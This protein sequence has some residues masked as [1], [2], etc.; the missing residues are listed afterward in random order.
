MNINWYPLRS[1]DLATYNKYYSMV[2]TNI[3]DLTFHCRFAW[4][5]VFKIQWTILEDCLVQ[6]SSG[7]G[8]SAPFM[9]MPLGKLTSE[10]I[11]KIIRAVHPIFDA[12]GWKFRILS[13]EEAVINTFEQTG[14]PAG[15]D[16]K[17]ESSDYFYDAE[18]L[19]TLAGK[20]YSKKRNHWSKFQRLYP[21]YQYESLSPAI[22]DECLK[23]VRIWAE[24]KGIDIADT[25]DSDYY[26]IKRVFDHWQD[27]EARGGAIRIDGK[28]VA[29]SIG[30]VGRD[31]VGFI[32]FEK[33]DIQY[34]GLYA[35][36][37]KLVLEN[38]FPTVRYVNREEDLGIPGLRK[39]KESYFPIR[40][41][42]KW[43]FQ[44]L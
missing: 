22:F 25:S 31:E 39:S 42:S 8:Y 10:K 30:S 15:I 5:N 14:I 21:D 9:L 23:L 12:K 7:G 16:Y 29:F 37:N 27:L 43:R 36:I 1:S 4:D 44:P 3:T 17:E 18:A 32:H 34:D 11:E 24:D 35:A 33:A 20:K 19:R 38:E 13:I 40:K 28:I 26:M 6:I 2:E 41:V